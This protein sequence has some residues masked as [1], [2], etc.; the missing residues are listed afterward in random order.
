MRFG[1]GVECRAGLA[2]AQRRGSVAAVFPI[3]TA[4]PILI[5][6]VALIAAVLPAMPAV[7]AIAIA[8]V[9]AAIAVISV[10]PSVAAVLRALA[11][12]TPANP[13]IPMST[14]IVA[15]GLPAAL[16]PMAPV[17]RE[18]RTGRNCY[19][20]RGR[21]CRGCDDL[22]QHGQSPLFTCRISGRSKE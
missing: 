10:R 21:E 18:R 14:T 11:A 4:K 17:L 15:L 2:R 7:V 13:D 3:M 19:C 12:A 20:R 1:C 22:T 16:V 9:V 6:A 8:I 5:V